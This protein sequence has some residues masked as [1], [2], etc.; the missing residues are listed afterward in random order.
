[1]YIRLQ[2]WNRQWKLY[3]FYLGSEEHKLAYHAAYLHYGSQGFYEEIPPTKRLTMTLSTNPSAINLS[4]E[5]EVITSLTSNLS[6]A[7]HV[8]VNIESAMLS[9]DGSPEAKLNRETILA[10]VL[11]NESK[12]TWCTLPVI[13]GSLVNTTF[14]KRGIFHNSYDHGRL[15]TKCSYVFGVL[16]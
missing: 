10:E 4:T 1:M 2:T 14:E 8:T 7:S 6:T 3:P 16:K 12:S 9:E 5:V 11:P 13:I 15:V